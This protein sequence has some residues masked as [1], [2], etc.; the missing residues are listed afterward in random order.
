MF[1][2]K[3]RDALSYSEDQG[4]P[5]YRGECLG[6]GKLPGLLITFDQVGELLAV[7][8]EKVH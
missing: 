3:Q 7:V 1:D 8:R 5:L 2:N 6:E 4:I